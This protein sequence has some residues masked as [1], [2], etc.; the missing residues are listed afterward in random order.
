MLSILQ[1]LR[2]RGKFSR[3]YDIKKYIYIYE[4]IIEDIYHEWIFIYS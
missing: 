1:Y 2:S 3:F 4:N